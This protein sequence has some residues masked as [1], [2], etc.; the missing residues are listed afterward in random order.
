MVY[1][2]CGICEKMS[3]ELGGMRGGI[4][5][6]GVKRW[7]RLRGTKVDPLYRGLV[8]SPEPGGEW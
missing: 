4:R 1:S 7:M 6:G 5:V 8:D 2:F 3:S